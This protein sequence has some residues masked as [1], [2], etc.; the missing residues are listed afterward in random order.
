MVYPSP[1]PAGSQPFQPQLPRRSGP[2]WWAWLLIAGASVMAFLMM[3]GCLAVV[4]SSDSSTESEQSTSRSGI[5][6]KPQQSSV[7]KRPATTPGMNVAVPDGSSARFEVLELRTGLASVGSVL[8]ETAQGVFNVVVVRVANTSEHPIEFTTSQQFVR[9]SGGRVFDVDSSATAYANDE[10]SWF[11]KINPGNAIVV[12]LVFD[13]PT[14]VQPATIFLR[15]S[16][17]R[18]VTVALR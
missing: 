4:A 2:P 12:E 1:P 5:T 14:G 7:E 17:G 10:A 15:A 8:T 9:D 16:G 13:M 6:S 3:A 18:P 11:N